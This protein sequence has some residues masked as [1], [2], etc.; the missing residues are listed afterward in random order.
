LSEHILKL[1]FL[2]MKQA[3]EQARGP[4]AEPNATTNIDPNLVCQKVYLNQD[5]LNRFVTPF[6]MCISGPSQ[7]Y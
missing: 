1:V 2:K 5:L 6:A 3:D 7:R 4:A